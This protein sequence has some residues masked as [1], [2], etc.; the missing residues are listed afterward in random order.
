[1]QENYRKR[2]FEYA[3]FLLLIGKLQTILYMPK[4]LEHQNELVSL[5][6]EEIVYDLISMDV[7]VELKHEAVLVGISLLDGNKNS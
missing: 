5:G 6:M 3:Y 2:K 7:N 1:M 4:K